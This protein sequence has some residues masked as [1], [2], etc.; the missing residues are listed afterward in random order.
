M[1]SIVYTILIVLGASSTLFAQNNSDQNPNYRKSLTKYETLSATAENQQSITI[2]DTYEVKDW[3]EEKAKQ[4]ELKAAR[5]HELR[6]MRIEQRAQN[7]RMN[8]FFNPY[9]TPYYLY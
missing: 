1:K 2:H 6:K 5:K 3:R 7:R 9:Y 8:P 4:K